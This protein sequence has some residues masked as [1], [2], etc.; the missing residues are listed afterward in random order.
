MGR[1]AQLL[2]VRYPVIQGAMGVI[3][4][5]EMVAAVSKAGGYG[6]LASAFLRD[7]QQLRDQIRAVKDLTD[8]PFG[9]NLMAMNPMSMKF[10]EVLM[11]EGIGAVTTSAGHPGDLVSLLRPNGVKVLHVVPT[12]EAA[13][14][15]EEA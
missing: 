1:V 14:K 12:V 4:N 2:G 5:P 15:A 7:P 3:S 8:R 10:A 13:L 9:A 11:E 6:L